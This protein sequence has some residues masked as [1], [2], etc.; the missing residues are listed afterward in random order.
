MAKNNVWELVDLLAGP[1][2]IGNKWVLKVKREA[3]G[4]INKFKAR[5][6]AKGYTHKECRDILPSGEMDV[7][8]AFLN[9]E[10]HEEIYMDQPEGFQEMGLKRKIH[11]DRSKKLLSLSQVTYIKRIIERFR[12]H[13]AN[14]VETPMDKNCVLSKELCPKTEEEK[15]RMTKIPYASAVET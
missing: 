5:L 1:K 10:L 15:K 13:N 6:V 12:M 4:S 9:G 14:P 3:D 2:T 8:T 7:K 11:R